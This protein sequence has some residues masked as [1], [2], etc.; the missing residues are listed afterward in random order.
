[1]T[2]LEALRKTSKLYTFTE[3]VCACKYVSSK[4]NILYIFKA[5]TFFFVAKYSIL[6]AHISKS[7][8]SDM[9]V[10]EFGGRIFY[11]PVSNRDSYERNEGAQVM[12]GRY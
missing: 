5:D 9:T 11:C 6:F 3:L 2:E 4:E 7:P 12:Q 10:T 1:M 8:E